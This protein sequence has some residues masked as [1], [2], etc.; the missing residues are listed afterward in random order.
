[1]RSTLLQWGQRTA[2]SAAQGEAGMLASWV[3][4]NI[5]FS[6][7]LDSPV[8]GN[9]SIPKENNKL[10]KPLMRYWHHEGLLRGGPQPI[11]LFVCAGPAPETTPITSRR[12]R[13]WKPLRRATPQNKT[14]NMPFTFPPDARAQKKC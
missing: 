7:A 14:R 5:C 9:G 6:K 4:R 13:R 11:D 1:M 10:L 2:K 3:E 8:D 12:A